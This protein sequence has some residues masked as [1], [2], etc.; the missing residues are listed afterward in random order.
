MVSNVTKNAALFFASITISIG[1]FLVVDRLLFSHF[2]N[3]SSSQG[4]LFPPDTE[5]HCNTPEFSYTT[6]INS[7]GF[8]DHEWNEYKREGIIRILA[9]GDS[10]TFGWGVENNQAWPKILEQKLKEY[11]YNVEIANLGRPGAD[12]A[13]YAQV[14]KRSI[15]ILKPDLIIL[16]TLQGDDLAQTMRQINMTFVA[17]T[18]RTVFRLVKSIVRRLFQNSY[19][20]V[21][22]YLNEEAKSTTLRDTWK[23]QAENLLASYGKA[24]KVRFEALDHSV[25]DLFLSGGLNPALV[26][27]AI[28]DTT[29]FIYTL[30]IDNPIVQIAL[31][32]ITEYYTEIAEEAKNVGSNVLVLSVPYGIYVSNRDLESRKKI[33]FS[34]M[35]EMLTSSLPDDAIRKVSDSSGLP[36]LNV[37]NQFR[38]KGK[39]DTLFFEYDGHFNAKGH[40]VFAD[41]MIPLLEKY[42]LGTEGIAIQL[43]TYK[44]SGCREK[45]Y[46]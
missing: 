18:K 19:T 44:A 27:L 8:R 35:P 13:A 5:F 42:I 20:V 14:A 46:P 26:N 38:V 33:G 32:Q 22:K 29:Y 16:A 15:P 4:F 41:S 24:E 34:V 36:F 23:E 6:R 43:N 31:K 21:W 10:F 3:N 12:P 11:G 17:K 45:K 28:C 1:L 39:T 40:M 9:I 2:V 37:T 30:D 7:L 25:K